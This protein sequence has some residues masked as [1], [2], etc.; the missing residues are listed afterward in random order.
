MHW[1]SEWGMWEGYAWRLMC[2]LPGC[3]A[4]VV[5]CDCELVRKRTWMFTACMMT[6][7]WVLL[8]VWERTCE[9]YAEVR[10]RTC[11]YVAGAWYC[12]M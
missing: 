10:K 1:V 3:G 7:E 2:V 11:R 12:E 4:L 9:L 8:E 5:V 6:V